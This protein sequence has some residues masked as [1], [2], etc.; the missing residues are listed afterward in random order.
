MAITSSNA[1]FTEAIS[2]VVFAAMRVSMLVFNTAVVAELDSGLG[3][4]SPTAQGSK[5]VI[6]R[7]CGGWSRWKVEGK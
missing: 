1:A 3:V 4:A 5:V 6:L 7:G 2:I